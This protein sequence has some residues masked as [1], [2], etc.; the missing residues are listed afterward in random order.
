VRASPH[1]MIA[2]AKDELPSPAAEVE[3]IR[4]RPTLKRARTRASPSSGGRGRSNER[5][6]RG[7][8]CRKSHRT[9]L[10]SCGCEIPLLETIGNN[11]S[12]TSGRRL[13]PLIVFPAGS[14]TSVEQA[15]E[16]ARPFP[17]NAHKGVAGA[18]PSRG[19]QA[20]ALGVDIGGGVARIDPQRMGA[21]PAG[22]DFPQLGQQLFVPP[23]ALW[24]CRCSLTFE[25]PQP[26]VPKS[27]ILAAG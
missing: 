8:R 12:R 22:V 24:H 23:F 3:F 6:A 26:D 4:L 25:P 15:L 5:R 11:G 14:G 20:I 21:A 2:L 1:P 18:G 19:D 9:S 27:L 7:D 10:A 13:R 16:L 17:A